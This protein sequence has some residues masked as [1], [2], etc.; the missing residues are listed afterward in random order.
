M[1]SQPFYL[2]CDEAYARMLTKLRQGEPFVKTYLTECPHKGACECQ[3]FRNTL[4]ADGCGIERNGKPVVP[5]SFVK[6]VAGKKK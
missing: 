3:F 6:K 1:N 4:T 2:V 5:L